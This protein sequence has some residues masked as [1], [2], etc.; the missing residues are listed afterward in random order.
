[1]DGTILTRDK[2]YKA[3]NSSTKITLIA[4]YL[5]TLSVG[6]HTMEVR[7]SDG[8]SATATVTVEAGATRIRLVIS[9]LTYTVNGVSK[10]MDVAPSIIE[11]RTVVPLRFIAEALGAKVTWDGASGTASVEL[12]GKTLKVTVGQI[13]P[14]MD[15]PAMILNDRTMVPLRYVSETL[16][17]EVVWIGETQTIDITREIK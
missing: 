14:G 6:N 10:T 16:G 5:D 4:A 3:E 13:A 2:D 1:M 9:K 17:C 11:S 15:V 8:T 12:N 7:F